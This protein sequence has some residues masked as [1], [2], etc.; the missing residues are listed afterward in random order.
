MIKGCKDELGGITF[1]IE[2]C[3]NFGELETVKSDKNY[4]DT[5]SAADLIGHN[6][7]W[8]SRKANR[9]RNGIHVYKS[10]G[11]NM[12][13]KTDLLDWLEGNRESRSGRPKKPILI[14]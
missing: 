8:L 14:T 1:R 3:K 6:P 7:F 11:K 2:S 12:F 10:G 4:L 5:K 9:D 13:K